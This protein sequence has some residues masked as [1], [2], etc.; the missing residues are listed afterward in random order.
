VTPWARLV[1]GR[2]SV[3]PCRMRVWRILIGGLLL[4]VLAARADEATEVRRI[5]FEVLGGKQRMEDLKAMRLSGYVIA[6]SKKLRF[7][8]IAARP[9]RC[10]L[11]TGADG[12]SLVQVSDGVEAP[13]KFDTGVWPPKYVAMSAAEGK[14]FAADAE[15]DDPL[16]AG[17]AR[18]YVY[19]YAGEVQAGERKNLLR[20]LVTRKLID[21]FSILVDP[22]TYFIVGRVEQRKSAGGRAIEITTRYDD[23]RPVGGVLTAHKITTMV[24][25]KVTQQIVIETA[26]ANPTITAETFS[27]P[28]AAPA[29]KK[30]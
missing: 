17:E 21:T 25:G 3:R 20:I 5:H 26:E 23:Y 15:F 9:N 7:S 4:G 11:E 1:V 16:V 10:R 22:E 30:K 14:L 13:W 12:R 6:G 8:M 2:R 24:D 28:K 29:A 27:R 19:D 18:G